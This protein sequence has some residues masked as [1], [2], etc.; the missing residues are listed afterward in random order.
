MGTESEGHVRNTILPSIRILESGLDKKLY[1]K[2]E[3]A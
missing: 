1:K 2:I 3:N